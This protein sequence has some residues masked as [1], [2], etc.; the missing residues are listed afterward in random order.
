M[1]IAK[2]VSFIGAIVLMIVGGPL[3]LIIAVVVAGLIILADTLVNYSQGKASLWDVGL[4]VLS[5][6]P[7]TKGFTTLAAVRDAFEAG[8]GQR[9]SWT[10]S[11][12]GRSA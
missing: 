10:S 8:G 5:R 1:V 3:W 9:P 2:I 6:I 4:A 11:P 12:A 7:I